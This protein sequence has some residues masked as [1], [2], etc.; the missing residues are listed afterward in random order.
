MSFPSNFRGVWLQP[1]CNDA[2]LAS[3]GINVKIGLEPGGDPTGPVTR[4]QF[5]Q[6]ALQNNLHCILPPTDDLSVDIASPAVIGW[7]HG[8]EPDQNNSSRV[9]PET[10]RQRTLGLKAADPT[11]L[12]FCNFDGNQVLGALAGWNK[13]DYKTAIEGLDIVSVDLHPCNWGLANGM[14]SYGAVL[15]FFKHIMVPEQHLVALVETSDENESFWHNANPGAHRPTVSE[16]QAEFNI[17]TS[18]ADGVFYFM[19]HLEGNPKFADVL[20]DAEALLKQLN[21]PPVSVST[22]PVVQSTTPQA[23]LADT[24]ANVM[25]RL[26]KIEKWING[27]GA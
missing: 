10:L 18:K 11:K 2:Y 21:A 5:I 8:D 19:H 16:I 27:Y 15:D 13:Y 24:V 25:A 26:E 14:V 17:A 1:R 12:I 3:L 4:P 22:T 23:S 9:P 7:M 20:P 6:S